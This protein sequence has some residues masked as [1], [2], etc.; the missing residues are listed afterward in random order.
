MGISSRRAAATGMAAAAA[1]SAA[2]WA[3]SPAL[4][5]PTPA[6]SRIVVGS[7]ET[8]G[9]LRDGASLFQAQ[10]R[11]AVG[12]TEG[13]PSLGRQAEAAAPSARPTV[14]IPA[15]CNVTVTNADV[16]RKA[17]SSRGVWQR[18]A[19]LETYWGA[20]D[21]EAQA[22]TRA[23]QVIYS[24]EKWLDRFLIV[25]RGTGMLWR[26]DVTRTFSADNALLSTTVRKVKV[27]PG[28]GHVKHMV[29]IQNQ[30][31]VVTTSGAMVRHTIASTLQLGP[32]VTIADKGFAGIKGLSNAGRWTI[33][34]PGADVVADF[35]VS[36]TT[37][38]MLKEYAFPIAA[39]ARFAHQTLRKTGWGGFT[40]VSVG[41]CRT[42]T[43]RHLIGV[44]PT[45]DAFVYRDANMFDANGADIRKVGLLAKG[46]KP[47]FSD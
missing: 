40:H 22:V 45:G 26:I 41:G 44:M 35:I 30:L 11:R 33:E 13:Q 1:L 12:E 36:T 28:W 46:W 8:T 47:I 24:A 42:G 31:Y 7:A 16:T 20:M 37:T 15:D 25:E 9:S 27:A 14:T 17:L 34:Q 43:A 29:R 21:I 18:G 19:L 10:V 3:G 23:K 39:P 32:A 5:V 4:A 6:H 2:G 38:G